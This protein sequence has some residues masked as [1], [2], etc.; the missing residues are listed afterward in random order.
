MASR[1][2]RYQDFALSGSAGVSLFLAF[3]PMSLSAAGLV[4][5]VPWACVTIR[6]PSILRASIMGCVTGFAWLIPTLEF[7]RTT[8]IQYPTG[9]GGPY[10]SAW[11]FL[12][13]CCSLSVAL[14][15]AALW[16]LIH[17]RVWHPVPAVSAAWMI[18][19]ESRDAIVRTLAGTTSDGIRLAATQVELPWIIA[20]AS[21]GSTLLVGLLVAGASGCIAAEVHQMTSS[22]PNCRRRVVTAAYAALICTVFLFASLLVASNQWTAG[23]RVAV[24]PQSMRPADIPSRKTSLISMADVAVWPELALHSVHEA[25][26]PD[27]LLG[28]TAQHI[29][30]PFLVGTKRLNAQPL[31]LHNSLLL[32][33]PEG[34]VLAKHDKRFLAPFQEM[35]PRLASLLGIGGRIPKN[36][37]AAGQPGASFPLTNGLAAGGGLCHDVCFPEWSRDSLRAADD[38]GIFIVCGS[39]S[40]DATARGQDFLL[41]CT[42]LRAVES[43]RGIVRCVSNGWSTVIDPFGRI[44]GPCHWNSPF[45]SSPAPVAHHVTPF[46]RLGRN[47]CLSVALTIAIAIDL[48]SRSSMMPRSARTSQPRNQTQLTERTT[49][50]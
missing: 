19:E 44:V 1:A 32:V 16:W 23:P 25:S 22:C 49:V 5:L 4:A 37:F 29:G 47:L 48:F 45:L 43:G 39:E 12:V 21:L 2:S 35:T 28:T 6:S 7:L 18:G 24:I 8:G 13:A 36:E 20:A 10:V 27:V 9:W 42:R 14:S 34:Q 15:S 31:A 38:I 26:K 41:A 50:P 3:P 11:A 17:H 40:F 46:I 30:I 33:S